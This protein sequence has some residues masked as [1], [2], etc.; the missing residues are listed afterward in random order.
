[1]KK[2]EKI[3]QQNNEKE[4]SVYVHEQR[5]TSF[6]TTHLYLHQA[7][8][9]HIFK[10]FADEKRLKIILALYTYERLC[11]QEVAEIL[12]ESV[13]NTSHHLRM[14]KKANLAISERS[15]KHMLYQL[16]DEHVYMIV[17]QAFAHTLHECSH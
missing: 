10:A 15:G 9:L 17:E 16:A 1:M 14:L 8:V 5:P 12:G 13:A 11:V 2:T 6:E 3:I 4:V 7:D